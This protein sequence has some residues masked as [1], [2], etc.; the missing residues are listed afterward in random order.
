MGHPQPATKI[1]IDNW[2][3]NG[4]INRTITQNRSKVIDMRF[5]WLKCRQAQ[6]QFKIYWEPEKINFANYFTKFNSPAHHKAVWLIYLYS[7]NNQLDIQGCIKIF[8]E[9][10][11][12]WRKEIYPTAKSV[13][14]S[15]QS[16][17]N[18]L[19]QNSIKRI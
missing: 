10:I 2:T 1:K 6:E 13:V 12:D 4:I 14:D 5:Y 18:K 9:C 16:I 15:D 3:A 19:I 11:T 7:K 17:Q 8:S